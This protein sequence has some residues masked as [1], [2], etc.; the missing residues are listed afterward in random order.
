PFAAAEPVEDPPAAQGP[1]EEPPAA[2]GPVVPPA[3]A[4]SPPRQR[5]FAR[6]L[7]FLRGPVREPEMVPM[8]R[9]Q[10]EPLAVAPPVPEVAEPV[11]EGEAV[12]PSPAPPDTQAALAAALD[13]LGQAH[14]R[15]YSRA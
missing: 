9:A 13:S 1:I 2:D 5:R 6:L 11:P 10:R 8:N 15:P 14:H 4:P 12:E 3:P 7:A